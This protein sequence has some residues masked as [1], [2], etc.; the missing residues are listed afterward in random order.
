MQKTASLFFH[1]LYEKKYILLVALFVTILG[2][3][4]SV[5]FDNLYM[6]FIVIIFGLSTISIF[7]IGKS[8]EYVVFSIIIT[9][10]SFLVIFSPVF[11]VLDE[12]AHY[13]RAQYISEG[14]FF[15]KNDEKSLAFSKDYQFLT[16]MTG[17]NGMNRLDPKVN[18]FKSD[19]FSKK[20]NPEKQ[21]ETKV[22]ATRPYG[23][24]AY[25]PS[26][27]GIFIGKVISNGNLGV[28]FYLGRFFN[29]LMYA[30]M[31]FFA[32][33]ISGRWKLLI[34]FFA[35]QHLPIYISAS[36]SQDAFFYGLSLLI[37]AKLIQL[38]DKEELIDK[39]DILEMTVLSTLMVF[40]KLPNIMLIGLMLFIPIN[41][42]KDKKTYFYNFIGIGIVIIVALAWVVYY[43]KILPTDL[44]EHVD[45]AAQ[46][47]FILDHPKEFFQV[48]SMGV[49][50]TT[51]KMRQYF[52]F[53]WS[54]KFS[55][56]AYLSYLPL[57]GVMLFMY[58]V[59]LRNRINGWFKF[60]IVGVSLAIIIL[61]NIIL[62]LSFTG[63]GEP[64]ILG[65]Q[66]RYFYGILI[67][68][69][70][71]FNL[72]DTLFTDKK[73]QLLYFNEERF[74]QLILI[75]SICF[76]IW[77]CTMRIGEYY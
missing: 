27:L 32:I 35:I 29:L 24:I 10:G 62:Y 7:L 73:N 22:K 66:G 60:A 64:T 50:S 63:V 59:K 26:A 17:Y 39:R 51:L 57:L 41:R 68:T 55:E 36:F 52:T 1:R 71:I 31:A 74:N 44:P 15:L 23:S 9:F 54:Y 76:M 69:P 2:A 43:S 16:E 19:L 53:G 30:L 48:L 33:K 6:K 75:I 65:V 8:I 56:I 49:M 5:A 12:P 4:Y 28:M 72:S 18:F 70:F 37:F 77:M 20:H 47:N 40:S 61:T 38:F 46:I 45:Q 34:G 11:D 58:P 13:A 67:L 25:M 42:Y 14:N 21:I 3:A